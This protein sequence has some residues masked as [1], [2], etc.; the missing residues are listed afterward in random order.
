MKIYV[1]G[2]NSLG[3]S[4][5]TKGFFGSILRKSNKYGNDS[6]RCINLL[7]LTHTSIYIALLLLLNMVLL[8]QI[9]KCYDRYVKGPTYVETKIVPQQNALFPHITFCA[10]RGGYKAD[11][12]EVNQLLF[13][14]TIISKLIKSQGMLESMKI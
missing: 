13:V 12:L 11:V 9:Y 14:F 6:L 4:N 7:K 2:R 3:T 5:Q 10:V 8:V 1:K